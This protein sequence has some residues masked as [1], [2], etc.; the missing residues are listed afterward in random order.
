LDF[1]GKLVDPNESRKFELDLFRHKQ[2]IMA[3]LIAFYQDAYY[4]SP[5]KEE[6]RAN[7]CQYC[8]S[9][10]PPTNRGVTLSKEHPCLPGRERK[11]C[12]ISMSQLPFRKYMESEVNSLDS[13]QLIITNWI[14]NQRRSV[15]IFGPAGAGKSKVLQVLR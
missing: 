7:V 10:F 15:F 14:I 13:D 3:P 8:W 4:R 9:C 2:A 6:H 12:L 1:E 11:G 5:H